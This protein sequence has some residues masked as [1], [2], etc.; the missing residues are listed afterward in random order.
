MSRYEELLG[1][2]LFFF[3]FSFLGIGMIWVEKILTGGV[4]WALL[5]RLW[6]TLLHGLAI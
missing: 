2:F 4:S 5:M 3:F 6:D 1:V